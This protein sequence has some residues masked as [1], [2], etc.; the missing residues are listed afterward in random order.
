MALPCWSNRDEKGAR[1]ERKGSS[2]IPT[3]IEAGMKRTLNNSSSNIFTIIFGILEP[4]PPGPLPRCQCKCFFS[5]WSRKGWGRRKF[6]WQRP[7]GKW[8]VDQ[9]WGL[10]VTKE[11]R[12]QQFPGEDPPHR[13]LGLGSGQTTVSLM[14]AL[15]DLWICRKWSLA[16]F[17][18]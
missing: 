7:W 15:G 11:E 3:Q 10:S 12:T 14:D 9:I 4:S 17:I 1:R 13:V 16:R 8:Q 5:I 2:G 6:P 18:N